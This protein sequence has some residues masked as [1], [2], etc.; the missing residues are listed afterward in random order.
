MKTEDFF[1]KLRSAYPKD[2]EM[3][4]TKEIIKVF[5]NRKGEHLTKLYL[6]RDVILLADNC[7]EIVIV[8]AKDFDVN[9]FFCVSLPGYIL[10]CGMKCTCSRLQTLRDREIF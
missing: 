2:S 9:P 5:N 8:S 1:S 10:Q 6:K 7:E 3:E 4:Q